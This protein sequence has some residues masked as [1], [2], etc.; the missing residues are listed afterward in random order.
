MKEIFLHL[1]STWV[2]QLPWR[3]VYLQNIAK[4]DMFMASQPA[5]TTEAQQFASHLQTLADQAVVELALEIA[6]RRQPP[7]S[8]DEARRSSECTLKFSMACEIGHFFG[9][10]DTDDFINTLRLLMMNSEGEVLYFRDASYV[11]SLDIDLLHSISV[12]EVPLYLPNA[13]AS[14]AM[15]IRKV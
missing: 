2:R 15:L 5:Q 9:P 11:R 7:S 4:P 3:F 6:P 14:G 12:E 8:E 10:Q 13:D 1:E